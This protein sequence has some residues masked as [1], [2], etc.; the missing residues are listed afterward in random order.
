MGWNLD[1]TKRMIPKLMKFNPR[2]LEE[3]V[4]ADD[5]H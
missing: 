5:I 3:P 4:I 2:W 1:Y